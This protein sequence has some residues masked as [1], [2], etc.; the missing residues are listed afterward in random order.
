MKTEALAGAAVVLSLLAASCATIEPVPPAVRAAE[1]IGLEEVRTLNEAPELDA[2]FIF[3]DLKYPRWKQVD[4]NRMDVQVVE[5][6]LHGNGTALSHIRWQ[7]MVLTNGTWVVEN[8]DVV[9]TTLR[10][11]VRDKELDQRLLREANKPG[12]SNRF[13][14]SLLFSAAR[15]NDDR[16]VELAI[17]SLSPDDSE[18]TTTNVSLD[19]NAHWLLMSRASEYLGDTKSAAAVPALIEALNRYPDKDLYPHD[20]TYSLVRKRIVK[21]LGEIGDPRAI[22]VLRNLL[23]SNH[24]E[25]VAEVCIAL[26]R[27]GVPDHLSKVADLVENSDYS[28]RDD[29]VAALGELDPAKFAPLFVVLL[30]DDG[31][32]STFVRIQAAEALMNHDPRRYADERLEL[33]NARDHVVRGRVANLMA[34]HDVKQAIPILLTRLEQLDEADKLELDAETNEALRFVGTTF[35]EALSGRE[36]TELETAFD[37]TIL[38]ALTKRILA[39]EQADLVL[40]LLALGDTTH[41]HEL[42][43]LVLNEQLEIEKLTMAFDGLGVAAMPLTRAMLSSDDWTVRYKVVRA[44]RSSESPEWSKLLAEHLE[45][46][47]DPDVQR[48][49]AEGEP[50]RIG[51][52]R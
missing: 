14:G 50:G 23:N 21:S 44:L 35:L 4:A 43:S 15:A 16:F 11:M 22:P 42:P 19:R 40:A 36:G 18:A 6:S 10:T 41:L 7:R 17:R 13:I 38:P 20:D 49:A 45:H 2:T 12:Q 32:L 39:G 37:Q 31:S 9:D 28:Y 52:P 1:A 5:N 25:L 33:L 46:E 3:Y 48:V 26:G 29:A 24:A 8:P 34:R 47:S 51:G 30:N 27:L